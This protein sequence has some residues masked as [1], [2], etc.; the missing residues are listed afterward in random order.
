M[1][2]TAGRDFAV[3]YGKPPHIALERYELIGG[4]LERI[5][6]SAVDLTS[7]VPRRESIAIED[8]LHERPVSVHSVPG[9]RYIGV[10]QIEVAYRPLVVPVEYPKHLVGDGVEHLHK[11]IP[12]SLETCKTMTV[13]SDV[14]PF[15]CDSDCLKLVAL[16]SDVSVLLATDSLDG[17]GNR[18]TA[19]RGVTVVKII[20]KIKVMAFGK[21]S[22]RQLQ[23]MNLAGRVSSQASGHRT[24]IYMFRFNPSLCGQ[25]P[26][27][28]CIP[29]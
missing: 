3:V 21:R 19:L 6:R 1:V 15:V 2:V 11:R 7:T 10:G 8:C 16:E 24:E 14:I 5:P 26:P 13:H 20:Q 25:V 29:R 22:V 23:L 27:L 18:M 9:P 28:L 4:P 17:L 12:L